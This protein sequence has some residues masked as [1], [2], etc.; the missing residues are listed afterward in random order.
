MAAASYPNFTI[1][2]T[3]TVLQ[4]YHNNTT[5]TSTYGGA[6]SLIAP[7]NL[8]AGFSCDVVQVGAGKVS[9][10]AGSGATV[11]G[12]AGATGTSGQ[13]A[14]MWVIGVTNGNTV[15]TGQIS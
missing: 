12:L 2:S 4:D 5:I 10:V 9:C 13:Y 7:A 8:P 15:I 1:G 11:N 14:V 3:T 6:V